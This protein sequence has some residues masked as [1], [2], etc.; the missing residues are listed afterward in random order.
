MN[1]PGLVIIIG[2]WFAGGTPAP[3]L[4]RKTIAMVTKFYRIR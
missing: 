4:A 1:N 2:F 3:Q